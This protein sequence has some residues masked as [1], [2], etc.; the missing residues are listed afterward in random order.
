MQHRA[1]G[2]ERVARGAGGGSDDHRV[3]PVGGE[4]LP[5]HHHI[6]QGMEFG[7]AVHQGVVREPRLAVPEGVAV[8]AN[9][10]A[11]PPQG[12]DGRGAVGRPTGH[13]IAGGRRNP[14]DQVPDALVVVVHPH[15]DRAVVLP[16]HPVGRLGAAV[17]ALRGHRVSPSR[18][19]RVR[20]CW[21]CGPAAFPQQPYLASPP[22]R[23]R[24]V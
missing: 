6:V 20:P 11:Q 21:L 10:I 1:V 14:H 8:V 2:R 22:C 9:H 3:R 12:Q 19:P 13:Q 4:M 15:H 18:Q 7:S 5:V 23:S 16:G 24:P 17:H